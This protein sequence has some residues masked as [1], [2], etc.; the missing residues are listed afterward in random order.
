MD[1]DLPRAACVPMRP[2]VAR[3]VCDRLHVSVFA[4][5]VCDGLATL[6][7]ALRI[8]LAVPGPIHA[9]WDLLDDGV[10]A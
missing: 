9:I 2:F 10:F 1:R 8:K 5:R 4:C 3:Y 7:P 6:R